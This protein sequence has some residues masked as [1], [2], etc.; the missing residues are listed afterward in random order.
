M[1]KNLALAVIVFAACAAAACMG[2][3]RQ[4]SVGPSSTGVSALMGT[5]TSSS[6]VASPTACT[7][8]RWTVTERSGNSA[9]GTFS[10][11]CP[12]NVRVTGT[13]TGVLNGTVVTWTA[14]GTASVPN[15]ASCPI[16]LSGTAELGSDSIRV[17]YSG[18]TCLGRVSGVE[19][20]RKN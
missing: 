10:A 20:L 18:D 7:D 1:K 6:L 17:P 9:S 15:F 2:Y 4:S 13:A 12:G 11:T 8:F 5:W 19:V 16:S 14:Q 3:D